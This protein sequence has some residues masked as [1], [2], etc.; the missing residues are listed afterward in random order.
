M[1]YSIF[2]SDIYG[3]SNPIFSYYLAIDTALLYNKVSLK[4][5]DAVLYVTI[6]FNKGVDGVWRNKEKY[7]SPLFTHFCF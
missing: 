7:G 6:Y 1:V 5:N 2:N 3:L 4:K